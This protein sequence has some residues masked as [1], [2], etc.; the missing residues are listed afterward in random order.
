[1]KTNLQSIKYI[2]D[3]TDI[4]SLA[5]TKMRRVERWHETSKLHTPPVL[6]STGGIANDVAALGGIV[7]VSVNFL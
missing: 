4:S 7:G 6:L 5:G 2:K 3:S 1:M